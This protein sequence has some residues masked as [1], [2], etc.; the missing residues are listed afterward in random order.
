MCEHKKIEILIFKLQEER[1]NLCFVAHVLQKT[2]KVNFFAS[3]VFQRKQWKGA[4]LVVF[5]REV[6]VIRNYKLLF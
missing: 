3:S 5:P 1:D 4:R 6:V 2:T